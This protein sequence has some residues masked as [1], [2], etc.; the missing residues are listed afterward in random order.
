MK[1]LNVVKTLVM[2]AFSAIALGLTA[3]S[4]LGTDPA[5]PMAIFNNVETTFDLNGQPLDFSDAT[6]EIP[7][8]VKERPN[9]GNKGPR[10][11]FERLLGALNLTPDQKA[12]VQELLA[13]HKDCATAAL[14]ALKAAERAILD[15]AKAARE[16]IKAGVEAGTVTREEARQ[17]LRDL[18]KATREAIKNLPERE[19]ARAALKECDDRFL[20]ALRGILTEDQIATLDKFV[21][22]RNGRTGG[23]KGGPRD[24]DKGGPRD[25]KGG[26]DNTGGKGPGGRGPRG[27]GSGDS[28]GT[29]GR[30]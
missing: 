12:Q 3:C 6:L 30:G 19:A 5:E 9:P 23:D 16:E 24:G 14:E 17:Q 27:G 26:K 28:T 10:H 13:A 8:E 18:N 7:M 20:A 4:E 15:R 11:P 2:V 22:A 1:T 25:D 29:G 21:A